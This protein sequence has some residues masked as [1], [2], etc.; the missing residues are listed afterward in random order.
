VSD[1]LLERI[2]AAVRECL[3]RCYAQ[4]NPLVAMAEY[5]EE[6]RRSGRWKNAEIALVRAR[7]SRLLRQLGGEPDGDE[8]GDG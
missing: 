1:H 6:L 5:F 8:S 4:G 2:N 3:A 7:V